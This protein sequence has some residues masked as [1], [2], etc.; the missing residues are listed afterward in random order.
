MKNYLLVAQKLNNMLDEKRSTAKDLENKARYE[1][2]EQKFRELEEESEG[3]DEKLYHARVLRCEAMQ[4]LNKNDVE[5]AAEKLE[6]AANIFDHLGVW[7]EFDGVV[8]K[9]VTLRD[10]EDISVPEELV[11]TY[12]VDFTD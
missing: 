10:E 4:L 5:E 7:D 6:E 12:K 1:K 8:G 2:A 3:G 9:L 11:E